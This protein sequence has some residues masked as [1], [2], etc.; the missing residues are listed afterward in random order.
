MPDKMFQYDFDQLARYENG[1][2]PVLLTEEQYRRARAC[3]N[4]CVGISTDRLE[5][6]GKPLMNHLF[7]ADEHAANLVKQRD[8]L[9]AASASVAELCDLHCRWD[10]RFDD[11]LDALDSAI[12]SAKGS[13]S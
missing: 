10:R 4:A 6:L 8:E 9:L 7:G 13:A 5:D 2:T 12:A 1:R 3:V 11:A